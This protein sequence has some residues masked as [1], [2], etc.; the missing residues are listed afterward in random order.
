MPHLR[1]RDIYSGSW[2]PDLE[3]SIPD[4]RSRGQQNTRSRI[5]DPDPGFQILIPDSRSGSRILYPDQQHWS[6]EY[7]RKILSAGVQNQIL[8]LISC[9]KI[10]KYLA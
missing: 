3:F 2:I 6:S 1:I 5:P 8:G 4:P 10:H 9:E 7:I